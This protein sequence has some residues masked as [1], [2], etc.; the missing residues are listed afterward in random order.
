MPCDTIQQAT[1]PFVVG[2]GGADEPEGHK[3]VV[4]ADLLEQLLVKQRYIERQL[5]LHLPLHDVLG[6]V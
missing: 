1:V 5:N 6:R 4:R 2:V 3:A